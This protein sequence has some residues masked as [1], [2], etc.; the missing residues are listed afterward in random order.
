MLSRE[1]TKERLNN[2]ANELERLCRLVR[3]V[4]LIINNQLEVLEETKKE[5][6]DTISPIGDLFHGEEFQAITSAYQYL[7][8]PNI[9]QAEFTKE[10]TPTA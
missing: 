2:V 10:L 8:E 3:N 1:E 5:I 6:A 4:G 9:I 7:T